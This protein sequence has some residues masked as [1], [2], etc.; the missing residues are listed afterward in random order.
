MGLWI[1]RISILEDNK[2]INRSKHVCSLMTHI[3]AMELAVNKLIIIPRIDT[4]IIT[5]DQQH[6]ES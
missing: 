6:L 3:L 2:A 1:Q 4:I 5:H